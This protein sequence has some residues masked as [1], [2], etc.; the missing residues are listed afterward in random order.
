MDLSIVF[1]LIFMYRK[2]LFHFASDICKSVKR[3]IQCFILLCKMDTDQMVNVFPEE[4]GTG[5]RS[6]SHFPCQ[7]LA[8]KIIVLLSE[9]TD[10]HQHIV[11]TLRLRKLKSDIS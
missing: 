4:A 3:C 11:G 5:N 10:I 9:F 2:R 7:V 8:K 6:H 1:C